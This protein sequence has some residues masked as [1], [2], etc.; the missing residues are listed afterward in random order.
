[1]SCKVVIGT[2]W[3]DEGKAKMIDYYT[4]SSDIIVRYQGGA[5]AGHT[6]VVKEK[7][8][9]FHLVPSGVLHPEKICVIGNG[10]VLDPLQLIS[11]LE[12]LEKQG[13]QVRNRLLISDAA[14]L[15]LPYHKT[16]D[17]AM[18]QVRSEK[19]GTTIRGIGPSYSDKCLRIGI[20]AGDVFETNLLKEKVNLALSVKNPQ[21]G[22][23]YRKGTYTEN[24]IMQ[25]M[26]RFKKSCGEMI[27]NTQ[28]YLHKAL[29]GGKRILLEGAQGFALDIDHGTYPYVTSSNPTIGGALAGTGLNAFNIDEVVGITKAYLTRVGEGPFPTEAPAKLADRMRV[30]GAEFG[31]TTGRPRRCGW[32]DAPLIRQTA[33]INGLTSIALTKLDVL[34][35]FK[36]IRVAVDYRMNGKIIDHFPASNLN[37]VQPV[38]RDL[39][40]WDENIRRCKNRD[41]LPRNARAYIDFIESIT[42]VKV[43]IVSVGPDRQST[44]R[45]G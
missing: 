30:N 2:Q 23:I 4:R 42:G 38:Y 15:I 34:S 6:V 37:R 18:E 8:F 17:E 22:R 41:E 20:R 11:E 32:F 10:V 35:G 26:K 16:M 39:D 45:N 3:G 13:F 27:V 40:G 5:N 31:S 28:H 24:D 21:L 25:I 9:I 29:A 44:F 1:M 19:I 36:K 12:S 33:R 43:S 7:K 14:H